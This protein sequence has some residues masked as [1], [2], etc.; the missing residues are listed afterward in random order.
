MI[1]DYVNL[2]IKNVKS[3]GIRSW[4]TMVGIFIGIAAVVSLISLGNAL[5]IAITGQFDVLDPNKLIIKNAETGFGP[6]GS[7]AVVKLNDHDV[8]V[9]KKANGVDIVVERLVRTTQV[10]YNGVVKYQYIADIPSDDKKLEV[11]YDALN[12]DVQSGKLLKKNDFG[13]VLLGNDFANKNKFGKEVRVGRKITIQG[14]EFEVAGILKG[15][16]SFL[17]NS[18]ILM[19]RKDLKRILEIGDEYDIL[20][21]QI[22]DEDK[23]ESVREDIE[24]LMRRDR[25]LDIGEEDFSIETPEEGLNMINTVLETVNLVVAAIAAISLLVGG[26]GI[27]NT[28]YTSVVER[29]KEI[30]VMKAIGA[31]NKDI[32]YLFLIESSALGF[33]GGMVGA[34]IGIGLA[35]LAAYEANAFLPGLGFEIAFSLPLISL[36]V[37]FSLGMG[38][39]FGIIPAVRAAKLKPVEALGA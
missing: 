7:T 15:S 33:I 1:S 9:V 12:L 3:R 14:E 11:I 38:T 25:D 31:K 27:A 28:M 16:G 37:I 23:I 19:P 10:E 22:K 4:L 2:T 13:K 6:P 30:G 35:Y 36:A 29:T 18:I 21:V 32:L 17:T 5:E 24:R 8:D 20:V 26:I 34:G 39:L